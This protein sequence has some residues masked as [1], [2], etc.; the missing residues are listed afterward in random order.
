MNIE[1]IEKQKRQRG[2]QGKTSYSKA[3]VLSVREALQ[4]NQEQE[5][6]EQVEATQKERRKALRG[7][8]GFTRKVWRT[9]F[10]YNIICNR[11]PVPK[12]ALPY[13]S[14]PYFLTSYVLLLISITLSTAAIVGIDVNYYHLPHVYITLDF[15]RFRIKS[16]IQFLTLQSLHYQYN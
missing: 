15:H 1:L 2:A 3:R 9:I 5:Q 8:I 13:D 10:L 6:K 4:K 14:L 16:F 11:R 7:V 12:L